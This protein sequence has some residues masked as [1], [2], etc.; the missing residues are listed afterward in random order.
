[1]RT[2]PEE[3]RS[4]LHLGG[5]LKQNGGK[6]N[7]AEKQTRRSKKVGFSQ[8]FDTNAPKNVVPRTEF[9][10]RMLTLEQQ[11]AALCT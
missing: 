6:V 11:L 10:Y 7:Q 3:Q 4:L 9:G 8:F 5:I 1:M 2:C